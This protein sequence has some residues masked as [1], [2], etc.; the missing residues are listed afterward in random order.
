MCLYFIYYRI[1]T[2]SENN[3]VCTKSITFN[4]FLKSQAIFIKKV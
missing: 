3:F 4:T 2:I 1:D